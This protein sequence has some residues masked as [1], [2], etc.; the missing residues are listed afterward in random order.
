MSLFYPEDERR[1]VGKTSAREDRVLVHFVTLEP[2]RRIVEAVTFE[3]NDPALKG[4]MTI[5]ITFE[6]D[7][8]GT[9]VT[10]TTSNLPPG[11]RPEDHD[12]GTRISLAQLG[13]RFAPSPNLSP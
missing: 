11:L 3:T 12:E 7:A 8:G 9:R 6:P 4:T 13:E 10:F 5:E 2:A 1:H